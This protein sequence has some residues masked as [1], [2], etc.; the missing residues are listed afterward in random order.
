IH[1]ERAELLVE[2]R[3][4]VFHGMLTGV[5]GVRLVEGVPDRLAFPCERPRMRLPLPVPHRGFRAASHC[6]I[7]THQELPGGTSA[8]LYTIILSNPAIGTTFGDHRSAGGQACWDVAKW[9]TRPSGWPQVLAPQRLDMAKRVRHVA[10]C[11]WRTR[12]HSS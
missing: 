9:R 8:L 1:V 6:G 3:G 12:P 4:D 11:Q 5:F 7:L 2:F 10:N